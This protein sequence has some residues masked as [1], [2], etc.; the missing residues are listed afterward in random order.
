[1]VDTSGRYA[2]GRPIPPLRCQWALM[3]PA[4]MHAE[5]RL[6]TFT[7]TGFVRISLYGRGSSPRNDGRLHSS[8]ARTTT[9]AHLSS[10]PIRL[11][12]PTW[13]P[14]KYPPPCFCRF[15]RGESVEWLRY[16]ATQPVRPV[17]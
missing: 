5:G 6:P 3:S 7:L 10:R 16:H 12:D 2:T 11:P 15:A 13:P 14:G 17:V 1:M 4:G 9:N 8:F